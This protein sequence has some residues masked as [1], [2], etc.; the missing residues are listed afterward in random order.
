MKI[1]QTV[2]RE[3]FHII[4]GA[5]IMSIL[6]QSVFLIIKKWDFTVLLGNLLMAVIFV[7][8]FFFLGI[9]LQSVVKKQD[10]GEIKKSMML[11]RLLRYGMIAAAFA[12][13]LIFPKL[14]NVWAMIPPL[15]FNRISLA[16]IA[17]RQPKEP[18][19][20][21]ATD[22]N[23]EEGDEVEPKDETQNS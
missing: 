13:G 14:F 10:S 16:V 21:P 3:T 15:F 8:D 17:A 12:C 6:E 1:D 19:D 11:S 5:L 2:K 7:L 22:E 23:R 9:T 18:H 20:S 4:C